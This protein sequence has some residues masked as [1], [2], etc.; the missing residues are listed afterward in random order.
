MVHLF[1]GVPRQVEAAAVLAAEGGLGE[2]EDGELEDERDRLERGTALFDRIYAGDAQSVR[3]MLAKGH[4]EFERWVLRHAYGRV[5]SRPGLS[6]DRRELL[7]VAA[8]AALGQERQLA[9]HARGALRCGATKAEIEGTLDA[10]EDLGERARPG[11][12]EA[13]RRIVARLS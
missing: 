2:L 11:R 6:A 10:I 13:A 7:A 8:L 4:P 9:G 1:G 12:I 5:L 3:A